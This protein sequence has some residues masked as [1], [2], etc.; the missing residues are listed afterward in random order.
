M[1]KIFKV[2]NK[3]TTGYRAETGT[4]TKGGET[5]TDNFSSANK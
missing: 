1:K 2:L 4:A 3:E 5:E